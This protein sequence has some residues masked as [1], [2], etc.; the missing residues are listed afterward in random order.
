MKEADQE[1]VS[2]MLDENISEFE[3]RRI[4]KEIE[5][6]PELYSAY[7]RY[8]LI[9]H[10][11]RRELPARL[12]HDFSE[13]VMN[14]LHNEPD[15]ESSV[16][17][18]RLNKLKIP[19]GLGVAALVTVFSLV[20][21]QNVIQ[22]DLPSSPTPTAVAEHAGDEGLQDFTLI[23]KAAEDFNSYIVNHAEYASPR[24]SMPHVRIVSHNRDYPEYGN[25]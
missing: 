22:P 24:V 5:L 14:R 10:A 15:T 16:R 3:V 1:L 25:E 19:I 18:T 13:E 12:N 23:P 9:G 17:S 20:I 6:D 21:V 2:R 8:S 4:L 7:Q 11:M